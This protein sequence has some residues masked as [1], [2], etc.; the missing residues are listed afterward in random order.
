M[1]ANSP[2]M[3]CLSKF[4]AFHECGLDRLSR[5]KISYFPSKVTSFNLISIFLALKVIN[6]KQHEF[7]TS[8]LIS[9][10]CCLDL[11]SIYRRYK[12]YYGSLSWISS[13]LFFER[14][15]LLF[16]FLFKEL[17]IFILCLKIIV[18]FLM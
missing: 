13:I 11:C 9:L 8:L 6:I 16:T 1:P 5:G 17:C 15:L 10:L 4:H 3:H 18:F 7:K 14:M 2:A 12:V